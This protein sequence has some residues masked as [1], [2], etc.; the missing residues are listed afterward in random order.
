[1]AHLAGLLN[2][3]GVVLQDG[4][5]GVRAEGGPNDENDSRYAC[6]SQ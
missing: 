5:G 2:I 3:V 1:M 6:N 4:V